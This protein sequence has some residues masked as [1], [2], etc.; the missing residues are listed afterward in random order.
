[1]RLIQLHRTYSANIL[2]VIFLFAYIAVRNV[3]QNL[4]FSCAIGI[5]INIVSPR[6]H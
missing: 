6:C 4:G 1:M 5:A 3:E 2:L